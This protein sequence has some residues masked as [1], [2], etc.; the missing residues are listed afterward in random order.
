M[1]TIQL[2]SRTHHQTVQRPRL[3][4]L[5]VLE[6]EVLSLAPVAETRHHRLPM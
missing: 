2:D 3:T 1:R 6:A 4:F 5:Q